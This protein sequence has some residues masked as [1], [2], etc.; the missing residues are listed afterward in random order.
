MIATQNQRQLAVLENCRNFLRQVFASCTDL[1]KMFQL[2]ARRRSR[3]RLSDMQ[4]SE[5]TNFIAKVSD[6][7][8]EAGHTKGGWS[9]LNAG[10]AC[11]VG[12]RNTN[13]TDRFSCFRLRDGLLLFFLCDR[14]VHVNVVSGSAAEVNIKTAAAASLTW[15]ERLQEPCQRREIARLN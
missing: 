6:P 7:S 4:V 15:E 1:E 10:H 8:I 13:H 2:I 9:K 14:S 5:I 3:L 11:S 12:Q